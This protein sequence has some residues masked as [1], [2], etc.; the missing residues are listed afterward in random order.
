MTVVIDASVAV[1]GLVP[2]SAHSDWAR[3]VLGNDDLVGPE[4][5]AIEVLHILRK[6]V[7]R[8]DLSAQVGEEIAHDLGDLVDYFLP[9]SSLGTRMWELHT[10]V[11]S[12]DASYVALAEALEA[13]L[14]TLDR[15][16][17]TAQGPRCDFL[18]PWERG[19]S[20]TAS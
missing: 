4:L 18:V 15:R 17:A 16:V 14:A 11:T 10:N 2:G 7:L 19:A 9:T 20:A 12:Y 8:G 3:E 6:A 5:L 1:A 13:P